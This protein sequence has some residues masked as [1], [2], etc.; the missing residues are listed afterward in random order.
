MACIRNLGG[1]L[2]PRCTIQR[3]N[4]QLVGTR[5]DRN[6][7][8]KLRRVDN[9]HLQFMVSQ[10]RQH[11]YVHNNPVNSAGVERL[12]KPLSLV[13]TMVSRMLVNMILLMQR[14]QN[15]FS[16]RLRKFGFNCFPMFLIDLMHEVELGV[17]RALFV[18]LLR[19]LESVNEYALNELDRR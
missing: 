13:P 8:I 10:A 17:W 19:I 11:I 3:S 18:H 9:D 4:A 1:C 2:C 15:T 14:L 6:D 5:K 12:L 16:A 7:R